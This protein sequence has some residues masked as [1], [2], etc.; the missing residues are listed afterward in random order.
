MLFHP[1]SRR[2]A[3]AGAALLALA[4]ATPRPN[5]VRAQEL[6]VFTVPLDWYPNA[7]HAGLFLAQERGYY[8]KEGLQPEFY[9]PQIQRP[10]CKQWVR[11]ETPSASRTRPTSC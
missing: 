9:T 8:E 3:L 11:D 6:D 5:P 7:N 10:C 4:A 1:F 2:H